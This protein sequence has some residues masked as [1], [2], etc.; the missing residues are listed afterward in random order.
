MS[1][2][3]LR[4]W[5]ISLASLAAAIATFFP[6]H[7]IGE[8]KNAK[9]DKAKAIAELERVG[10]RI[11]IDEKTPG[12][13]V[14]EVDF[15]IS[16]HDPHDPKPNDATLRY[17]AGFEQLRVLVLDYSEI[18]DRGM[19]HL[20]GLTKLEKLFIGNTDVTDTG[21]ANV[22]RMSLL[23]VLDLEGCPNITDAGLVHLAGLKK[24]EDLRIGVTHVSDA[25]VKTLHKSL[26]NCKVYRLGKLVDATPTASGKP[27]E[28][29]PVELR[30]LG[31]L[32]DKK[33]NDHLFSMKLSNQS[34]KPLW[35]VLPGQ[36]DKQ[37]PMK[38]VFRHIPGQPRA[39]DTDRPPSIVGFDGKGKLKAIGVGFYGF[40]ALYLP[41]HT[42]VEIREF[43]L[44]S[45]RETTTD[46]T[47][48]AFDTADELLVNG[49]IPLEK[50][51]PFEVGVFKNEKLLSGGLTKF[52]M[53][54]KKAAAA[55]KEHP[56]RKVEYV[57]AKGAHRW[58]IKFQN[59]G[60]MNR[61]EMR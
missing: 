35:V 25:G 42:V 38:T 18:T 17:I 24:L 2:I 22:K 4:F 36:A 45:R 54:A 13:D 56:R 29:A 14:T 12:K 40:S 27:E 43:N 23:R 32:R 55:E 53:E 50:W 11:T 34:D 21:L 46:L 37:P 49:K 30:H 16:M 57:E 41:S 1:S 7:A 10:C 61:G 15:D 28:K 52:G 3:T 51:L 60:E 47:E 48:I 31:Y 19:V 9:F 5:F 58:T 8:P 6:L 20:K 39:I 59:K 44:P 33:S 26:P